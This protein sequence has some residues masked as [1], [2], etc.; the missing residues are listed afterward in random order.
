MATDRTIR[1]LDQMKETTPNLPLV[2]LS[3]NG[4]FAPP[5]RRFVCVQLVTESGHSPLSK[6]MTK[7]RENGT[8]LD[9][10]FATEQNLLHLVHLELALYSPLL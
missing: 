5:K 9:L 3:I 6:Q 2:M 7:M 4:G 10:A 1:T 8:T